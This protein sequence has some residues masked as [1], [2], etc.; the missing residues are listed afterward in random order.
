MWGRRCTETEIESLLAHEERLGSFLEKPVVEAV[1]AR[2][3][4]ES[5]IGQMLGPYKVESLLGAGGMGMVYRARDTRLGRAVAIKFAA[6]EFSGRFLA[7]ARAVAALNHPHVCT[8]YDV[9]PNYLVMELLEG[10][11]LAQRLRSGPLP[12]PQVLQ[13]AIEIAEALTAAHARGIIHRDL[14]PGN[15]MITAA[16]IKVLDFGLAKMEA[17]GVAAGTEGPTKS[18]TAERPTDAGVVVGTAAYMSPE[19]ARGYQLDTRSDLFSFGVVLYEMATGKRPF[20]GNTN[21]VIFEAILN[22]CVP[23]VQEMN[24]KLSEKL[25]AVIHKALEKDRELRYQHASEIG[26]DLKRLQRDSHAE[27]EVAASRRT[28]WTQMVGAGP[29]LRAAM[30]G[31]I[32]AAG[33][34]AVWFWLRPQVE[35]PLLLNQVPI[36]NDGQTKFAY[37]TGITGYPITTDGPRIF[38][39]EFIN[40]TRVIRE[41][42][43]T[44][45]EVVPVPGAPDDSGL[46]PTDSDVAHSALLLTKDLNRCCELWAVPM[47]GGSPRRVGDFIG[48]DGVWS[49][50]GD[51]IAYIGNDHGE[52]GCIFVARSDGSEPRMVVA[53]NA[54]IPAATWVRWSPDGNRMRFTVED[55]QTHAGSLWE[56][57][58]DGTDLHPLLPGWSR[59]G[60]ECCG[61]WT[62]D[63]RYFVFESWHDGNPNIWALREPRMLHARPGPVRLTNGPLLYHTPVPSTNGKRIFVLAVQAHGDLVKVG[64]KSHQTTPLLGRL[65]I[66]Q[67]DFSRDGRWVA[68]TTYPDNLLWRSRADGSQR[69]QLTSPGIEAGTPRWSPDGKEIAFAGRRSRKPWSIFTI[70]AQGGSP[71]QLTTEGIDQA[72]PDWSPDGTRLAFCRLPR[73]AP[74]EELTIRIL[75]V[76]T[77][78]LSTL[79]HRDLGL[80]YPRWSPDGRYLAAAGRS[81]DDFKI[82]LLDLTNSSWINLASVQAYAQLAWSRNGQNLY[83]YDYPAQGPTIY[84]LRISDHKVEQVAK[85]GDPRL[86]NTDLGVMSMSGL[87]PDESP[88]AVRDTGTQ[89]L[90]A[91]EVKLP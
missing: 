31:G 8:L 35:T 66:S 60:A 10:G 34:L 76:K 6:K 63:G 90:Y 30:L 58:A 28:R 1:S 17:V 24:P 89:E 38:F 23:S 71:H 41:V 61:S 73:S 75:E 48:R 46:F 21:A 68:Y 27:Q 79:L 83:Y 47:T 84:R 85:L 49:Q 9:G 69:L 88:I 36:T 11:T 54:A 33:L 74:V 52:N 65:S 19:Q 39:T 26:A 7:E 32:A 3:T 13:Y 25:D 50:G 22:R 14:K 67:A 78:K 55:P 12:V 4:V 20:D 59:P 62:P 91:L 44:G 37:W 70:A 2:T 72:F 16:G 42:S 40:G 5:P 29:V 82:M 51:R 18:L 53:P 57:A 64:T 80:Y 81:G 87:A 77:G 43:A 15:I 86:L 45:G 56:V